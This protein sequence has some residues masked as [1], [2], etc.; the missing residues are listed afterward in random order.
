MAGVKNKIELFEKTNTVNTISRETKV[1]H[2]AIP[3]DKPSQEKSEVK[4]RPAPPLTQ[5]SRHSVIIG[6]QSKRKFAR[7]LSQTDLTQTAN[8]TAKQ[9]ENNIEEVCKLLLKGNREEAT[10]E[11]LLHDL[12]VIEKL[13]EAYVEKIEEKAA[14]AVGEGEDEAIYEN[15]RSLSTQNFV[16]T[17]NRWD[18]D[19]EVGCD[20]Y[21][22]LQ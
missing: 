21:S 11:D 22:D 19:E 20:K 16:A 15:V 6:G 5:R 18:S 10:T 3:K 2:G 7:F 9:N 13:R 4:P 17:A 12:C 14:E 8:N 1:S